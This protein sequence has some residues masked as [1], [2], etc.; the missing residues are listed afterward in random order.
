MTNWAK[1]LFREGLH[2]LARKPKAKRYTQ[3]EWIAGYKEWQEKRDD[4]QKKQ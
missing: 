2:K 1:K 3:E 4:R